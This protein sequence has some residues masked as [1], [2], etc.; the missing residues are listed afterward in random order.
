MD[1]VISDNDFALFS[2][3]V[4]ERTGINLHFGKKQLLQSRVN[5]IL[6][7]RGIPSYRAYYELIKKDN[8]E[9]E[10]MEFIN[11][12]STNVTHFFREI[13]HFEFL[14]NIWYPEFLK[15]NDKMIN[16]W[17]SACSS[18]E[19]PYSIAIT[20]K[21]LLSHKH[22]FEILATDISTKV[23]SIAQR[24]IYPLSSLEKVSPMITK[25]YF[26]EGKNSAK[27]YV[28]IKD[29]LK[30]HIVFEKLN[31]IEPFKLSSK[32]DVIF[33]RNVM[34]YFDTKVKELIINKMYN[35]MNTGSYL[36][37]GHSESLNGISHSFKY[38]M[39]AIYKK[40]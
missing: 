9:K 6:R 21:E 25:K 35:F 30:Q 4:Y 22:N 11:L 14:K 34:I 26:F 29:E 5:K 32:Y 20:L 13:K 17:S 12:I 39:P 40:E 10:L 7:I 15:N 37:I 38:I 1:Y 2:K 8:S 23:L 36:M 18:G 33:C 31:L 16:I 24:G 27:G 19:E 3:L 28:K